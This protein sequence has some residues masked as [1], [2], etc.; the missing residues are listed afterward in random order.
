MMSDGALASQRP[1]VTPRVTSTVTPIVA[2]TIGDPAGIGAEVCV[3]AI[4]HGQLDGVCEP[5]LIGD[6]GVVRRAAQVCGIGLPI[7]TIKSIGELVRGQRAIQVLDPGSADV[8][9]CGYGA[10][11]AAAGHAVLDWI[12]NG[13]RL[14]AS[15]AIQGLVMGP[16]DTYS[17]LATGRVQDID[18]LQPAN[19]FMLRITGKLRAVPLSE[20]VRLSEAIDMV[21]PE[22]VLRVVRLVNDTLKSWGVNAP[23][24][25]VAGINPHAM[26]AEDREKIGP[27]IEQAVA[28][29][30]DAS[31]P[32]VP[33]A[34]F[35]QTMEGRFD[36]VV[37]MFHDQGQIAV[38]TAGFE[39]ACTVYLG[40]PYV[41]LNVPHGVAFDIAGT[42][43]AQ[44][45]SMLAAIRTAASLAAGHGLGASLSA[46][47]HASVTG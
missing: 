10:P 38:K 3:S 23:R 32:A 36:A 17:V 35:R 15:G 41:M 31:G 8:S 6:A 11:S 1:M 25:A 13:T 7:V 9:A 2:I 33:D 24:I 30:I 45:R 27:A 44:H 37:T 4:A 22:R 18:E 29:G 39:G 40:L 28:L 19:T 16:I 43:R 34:V 21:T 26:F 12:A 14:G 46:D 5:L 47:L 42:G 20:H